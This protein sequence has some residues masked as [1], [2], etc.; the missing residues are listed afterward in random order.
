MQA[1]DTRLVHERVARDRQARHH[2]PHRSRAD[3]GTGRSACRRRC[4]AEPDDTEDDEPDPERAERRQPLPEHGQR[5]ERDE[6]DAEPARHRIDAG[7]VAVAVRAP[8]C[9]EIKRVNTD[10]RGNER[11]PRGWSGL[12]GKSQE[13]D[14]EQEERRQ[15]NGRPEKCELVLR[16]L[17]QRVP[18]RVQ[19]GGA[20]DEDEGRAAHG[21]ILPNFR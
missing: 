16:S 7:E 8:E 21:P 4:P 2:G 1:R 3:R 14:R 17:G 15:R 10:A 19:N 18:G 13:A 6:G 12:G 11:Q 9:P 5:D 20:H